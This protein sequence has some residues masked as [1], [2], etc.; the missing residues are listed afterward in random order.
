[1]SLDW[2]ST[3]L[4]FVFLYPL[5]GISILRVAIPVDTEFGCLTITITIPQTEG[6]CVYK[7]IILLNLV[8]W[9]RSFGPRTLRHH[10]SFVVFDVPIPIWLG[11]GPS[12]KSIFSLTVLCPSLVRYS[13][14]ILPNGLVRVDLRLSSLF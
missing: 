12:E 9:L 10:T 13:S 7:V 2:I 8:F 5:L 6:Y 4:H 3:K 1:M 14:W 11:Y